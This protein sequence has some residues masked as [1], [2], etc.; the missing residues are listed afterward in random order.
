MQKL[1]IILESDYELSVLG[2]PSFL[3]WLPRKSTQNA[4]GFGL[5]AVLGFVSSPHSNI[6]NNKAVKLFFWG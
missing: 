3:H 2:L 6:C 4:L 1:K 5:V